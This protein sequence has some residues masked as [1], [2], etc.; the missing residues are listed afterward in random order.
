MVLPS[1]TPWSFAIRARISSGVMNRSVP[2][3][4]ISISTDLHG[5]LLRFDFA[6][7]NST[8]APAINTTQPD[9]IN[10]RFIMPFSLIVHFSRV[11]LICQYLP[12]PSLQVLPAYW[13]QLHLPTP[14]CC[15]VFYS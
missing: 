6:K 14:L 13:R 15:K 11:Q 12:L 4:E 1:T 2:L 3:S 5:V 9:M 8:D 10:M 7:P